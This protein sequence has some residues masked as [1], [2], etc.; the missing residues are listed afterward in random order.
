MLF[1]VIFLRAFSNVNL[2]KHLSGILS[3]TIKITV[4]Q[5]TKLFMILLLKQI[6]LSVFKTGKLSDRAEK[7]LK[8]HFFSKFNSVSCGH[9]NVMHVISINFILKIVLFASYTGFIAVLEFEL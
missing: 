8:Q 5:E 4:Y 2:H 7:I 3:H 9:D 1:T 6:S